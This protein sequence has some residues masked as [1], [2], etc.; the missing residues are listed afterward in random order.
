VIKGKVLDRDKRKQD[1]GHSLFDSWSA[2]RV[3]AQLTVPELLVNLGNL[4]NRYSGGLCLLV[5]AQQIWSS[6]GS[7]HQ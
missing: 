7:P 5:S 1:F 6:N 3:S 2:L 4:L